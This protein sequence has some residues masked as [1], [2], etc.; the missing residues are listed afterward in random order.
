MPARSSVVVILRNTSGTLTAA[1]PATVLG[2][3]RASTVPVLGMVPPD[4]CLPQF[5]PE[6]A[7]PEGEEDTL[8]SRHSALNL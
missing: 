3:K 7:H 6:Q 5:A 1:R 8:F 4:P 2:E